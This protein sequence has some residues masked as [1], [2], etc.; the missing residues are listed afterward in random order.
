MLNFGSAAKFD[1]MRERE[2]FYV[3]FTSIQSKGNLSM[4]LPIKME[5]YLAFNRYASSVI[6]ADWKIAVWDRMMYELRK[7]NDL[8]MNLNI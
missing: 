7:T 2:K 4:F 3:K 1:L 6:W 8:L 5:D